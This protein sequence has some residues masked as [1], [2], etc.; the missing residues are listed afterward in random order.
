MT[1]ARRRP[2]AVGGATVP[3]CGA[4]ETAAITFPGG[5]PVWRSA[6]AA[7]AG[8]AGMTADG[9]IANPDA[10]AGDGAGA[11]GGTG[12]GDPGVDA[13]LRSALS[14]IARR[15]RAVAWA[16]LAASPRASA[17]IAA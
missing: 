7:A 11:G 3:T 16:R 12:G 1:S 4:G 2:V 14:N 6:G 17:A 8:F 15:S 10:G 13:A 9:G 5:L